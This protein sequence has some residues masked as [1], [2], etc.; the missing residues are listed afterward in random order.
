[1]RNTI[2][3]LKHAIRTK[4]AWPGGCALILLLRDGSPLCVECGRA[5]FRNILDS[6]KHQISD[7]WAFE[8]VF[9][10]YE[11]KDCFCCH[12]GNRLLAEYED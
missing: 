2:N 4:Y 9:I 6:T 3:K 7:G 8:D 11:D 1:M 10:N 5:E 12:C